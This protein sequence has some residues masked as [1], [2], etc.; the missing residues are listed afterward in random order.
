MA[1]A[2]KRRRISPGILAGLQER[3]RTAQSPC[4]RRDDDPPRI[5]MIL[6][7]L[8]QGVIVIDAGNRITV[9]SRR[10]ADLLDLPRDHAATRPPAESVLSRLPAA[11][12]AAPAIREWSTPDERWIEATIRPLPD[13]GRLI[14]LVETTARHHA[15]AAERRSR[16]LLTGVIDAIPAVINVKD[17]E[18]R[19]LLINR[20]QRELFAVSLETTIGRTA[21]QAI[22]T[23]FGEQLRQ[24]DRTVQE[25]GQPMP[26]REVEFTDGAGRRRHW[27]LTKIPLL[28]ADGQV[29]HIVSFAIDIAD[30]IRFAQELERKSELLQTVV[31]SIGQGLSA[32]D[33]NLGLVAWNR[34]FLDMLLF[35]EELGREGR[36]FADFMR[37]NAERGDYGPCDVEAL[38]AQR[39]ELARGSAPHRFE[40]TLPDGR[41]IE[42]SAHPIPHG[43]FVSTVTDITERKRDEDELRAAKERAEQALAELHETQESLIQ[44]EKMASLGQ[45]V[46]GVAHEI[47]TP[48]GVALTAASHLGARTAEFAALVEAGRLRRQDLASYLTMAVETARLTEANIRRAAE[49]IQS[50]KQV[51]VD[52]ASAERRRFDLKHYVGEVLISLKPLLHRTALTTVID[53]P[54]SLVLE[55]YPGALAQVLANLVK[56]SLIHGYDEPATGTLTVTATRLEADMVELRYAD[57]GQG[58]PAANLPKI[59]DPFFTTRRNSGG[60]GLGLH[61]VYNIVTQTLRGQITVRSE[62]G[63]GTVFTLRLPRIA[64][65][66]ADEVPSREPAEALC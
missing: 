42:V 53:I 1:A 13:G 19:Y 4:V 43:G 54:D 63:R 31:E 26:F 22:G 23:D 48:V 21:D 20:H 44:A 61:I 60:S 62:P 29:A 16:E 18:S 40:R 5:E 17:R 38:V 33:E 3:Y 58:I 37:Y 57:D 41:V 25:T 49:L 10:A 39:V 46:A 27:W 28:D 51:A 50:F 32:F 52:R 59:F 56:N 2:R 45:L 34:R 55:G 64:P 6:D 36:P 11:D 66:E 65:A 14:T 7:H 9:V 47:N 24:F 35:P 15:E 30:R 8:E 12:G